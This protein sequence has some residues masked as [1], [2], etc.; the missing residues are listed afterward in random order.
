M[1]AAARRFFEEKG[2]CE[3]D[4]PMI[5]RYASVDAHI[6]L[7]P[8][9]NQGGYRYLHT[10]PEYCMKRLLAEGIGD[11]YQL[12]HVFR[13]GEYSPKHNPEFTM[14]EWYRCGIPFEAMIEETVAFI[15]L[16]LGKLPHSLISYRDAIKKYIGIDYTTASNEELLNYIS[17]RGLIPYP[18]IEN[19]GKDAILNMIL[20][21]FVEPHLGDNELTVLA[22]Y[23]SSQAA[24]AKTRLNGTESVAERFEIYYNGIE[25][26][27]G[28]HE[29][30]D[31]K[32]QRKRFEEAN[33][34]RLH[35]GKNTLPIDE[36]FL[37][38]LEKGLPD[39]CGVAV[40]VDRLMMLRHKAQNIAQVIPFDWS[41]A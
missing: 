24:L 13:D 34:F 32:E 12:G 9:V 7:I 5:T 37:Q 4:C 23:P 14:A 28:Y 41:T 38:A 3:V 40:G 10:S 26:C 1:L 20:G 25:L 39:S 27:N 8:V 18:G 17:E 2:V 16:F 15:L 30:V 31:P 35:I 22:Y 6:D 11:I 21:S 36:I 19:E 29:L 33:T